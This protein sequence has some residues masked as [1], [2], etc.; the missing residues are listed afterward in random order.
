MVLKFRVVD[1]VADAT[2][3]D[4]F[5]TFSEYERVQGMNI[6][7]LDRSMDFD[8]HNTIRPAECQMQS[9]SQTTPA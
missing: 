2:P 4:H 6:D 3:V 5:K 9:L 8:D 1:F 7:M